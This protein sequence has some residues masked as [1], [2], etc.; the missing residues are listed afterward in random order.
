MEVGGFRTEKARVGCQGPAVSVGGQVAFTF[1]ELTN[2][3]GTSSGRC[4]STAWVL[5]PLSLP[6]RSLPK[7]KFE[8]MYAFNFLPALVASFI[9]IGGGPRYKMESVSGQE[10][11]GDESMMSVTGYPYK[12][13]FPTPWPSRSLEYSSRP[14]FIPSAPILITHVGYNVNNMLSNFSSRT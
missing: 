7:R 1:H 12:I 8:G 3:T 11:T 5:T 9:V 14:S 4:R 2:D 6:T 10:D 13:R